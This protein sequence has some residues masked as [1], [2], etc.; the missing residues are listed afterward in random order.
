MKALISNEDIVRAINANDIEEPEDLIN[1]YIF[2]YDQN[3]NT[4]NK[5]MTFITVCVNIPQSYYD[6]TFITPSLDIKII[7]H[8]KN[9]R[10]DNIPKVKENRNDY[11]AELIDRELNG[12]NIGGFGNSYL[13]T[14]YE[15]GVQQDYLYRRLVFKLTDLNKS[16]C[17]VN[18]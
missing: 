12:K 16:L 9:M 5:I 10:I 15:G 6:H 13:D 1:K 2:D 17:N 3:P 11:L 18:E 8:E 4:L 14:N 7:S